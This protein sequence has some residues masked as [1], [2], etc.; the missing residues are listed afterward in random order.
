MAE[1]AARPKSA[2]IVSVTGGKTVGIRRSE[3]VMLCDTVERAVSSVAHARTATEKVKTSF[4]R[5]ERFLNETFRELSKR[6]GGTQ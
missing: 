4:E 6:F 3:L 5:E 1:W 2:G